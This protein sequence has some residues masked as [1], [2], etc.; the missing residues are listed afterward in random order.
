MGHV[1]HPSA[2]MGTRSVYDAVLIEKPRWRDCRRGFFITLWYNF[3][4]TMA[5]HFKQL[6]GMAARLKHLS[7][8]DSTSQTLVEI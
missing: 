3:V 7:D 5:A 2:P 1:P 6:S 4:L 8:H